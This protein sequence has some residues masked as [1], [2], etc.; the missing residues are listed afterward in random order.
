MMKRT[1]GYYDVNVVR[2]TLSKNQN[3][4]RRQVLDEIDVNRSQRTPLCDWA[5]VDE[6]VRWTG[7][8]SSKR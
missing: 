6:P 1:I 2:L 3:T 4:Y 5:D 7:S 8:S